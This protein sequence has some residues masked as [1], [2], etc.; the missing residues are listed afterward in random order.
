MT[1]KTK[2]VVEKV[3]PVDFKVALRPLIDATPEQ[4]LT[5]ERVTAMKLVTGPL[6]AFLELII[7]S[8]DV[9]NTCALYD[10]GAD[11]DSEEICKDA[12]QFVINGLMGSLCYNVYEGYR[13]NGQKNFSKAF[14]DMRKAGDKDSYQRT[15]KSAEIL[16]GRIV[17]CAKMDLQQVY[18]KALQTRIAELYVAMTGERYQPSGTRSKSAPDSPEQN[19]LA[20]IAARANAGLG[21]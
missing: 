15:E 21:S 2:N 6:E 19:A 17:W 9:G 8:A 12:A 20:R 18:R 3:A 14:D 1:A 10:T 11:F 7:E 13:G 4:P 16:Q 5:D